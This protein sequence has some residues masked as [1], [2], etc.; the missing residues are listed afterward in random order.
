MADTWEDEK[1]GTMCYHGGE[2]MATYK[3]LSDLDRQ[4]L[5]DKLYIKLKD[6]DLENINYIVLPYQTLLEEKKWY[7][8]NIYT[9]TDQIVPHVLKRIFEEKNIDRR[10][11]MVPIPERGKHALRCVY[12]DIC[13]SFIH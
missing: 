13:I 11:M 9:F 8:S 3:N 5:N 4:F 6:A 10:F 1:Y 12:E 2:Y 7:Q